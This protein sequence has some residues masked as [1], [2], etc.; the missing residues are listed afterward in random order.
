MI[1]TTTPSIEGKSI[2]TAVVTSWTGP[3][4]LL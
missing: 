3:S 2:R 4:L 1:L